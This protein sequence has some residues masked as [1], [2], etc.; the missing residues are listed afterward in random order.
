MR[1]V[2]LVLP[3]QRTGT[4]NAEPVAVRPCRLT[5]CEVVVAKRSSRPGPSKPGRTKSEPKP[6]WPQEQHSGEGSA[7]ALATLQ[8]LESRRRLTSSKPAEPRSGEDETKAP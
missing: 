2:R 1:D 3:A 8:K 6:G 5:S 4:D 7:S